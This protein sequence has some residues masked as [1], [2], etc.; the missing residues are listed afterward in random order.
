MTYIKV[1]D[2][3]GIVPRTGPTRLEANQA[4]IAYNVKLQSRELRSWSNPTLAY[5]PATAGVKTIYRIDSPSGEK[6]WLEW[7]NDV[8]MVPGPVADV[9]EYRYYYTGD[10]APKKTN[11]ALAT[12]SGTGVKPF[13]NSW[14]YMGVPAPTAGPTLVKTG[15]SG[16][17]H[18]DRAYVYTY[19]STFGSVKEESGPSPAT[20][21]STVEPNATVTVSGFAAAPTTGYNITHRRIYRTIVGATSVV[22]S[23]V[24][25]IPIATTSY[26]DTKLT[27][28]LG[29]ALPSLYWEPPPSDLQGLVAMPNGILAA[30]KG[31]QIWFSEPYYPHSWPS[32]YMLTVDYPIVGLGVFETTLVVLT[33]RFP[34]LISGVSPTSMTQQKLP[35]PQPCVSKK[36]IATD[37]YGVLYAS[38]SGLV[39]IGSG[40]QDVITTPLYTHD[41]WTV[42]APESMIAL[43]YNNLYIAFYTVNGITSAIVLARGDIPPLV[44]LDYSA[45]AVFVDRSTADIFAVSTL[46]NKIYQLDSSAVNNTIY[47]W[48]SKKF[49]LPEPTNFAAGKVQADYQYMTDVEAYNAFVAALKAANL[50]LYTASGGQVGGTIDGQ[51]FNLYTINGSALYDIP[52]IG[53]TRFVNFILYAD[54]VQVFAKN[55]VNQEPFRLPALQKGYIYEIL[56]SGNVPVRSAVIAS[57]IGELR[58]LNG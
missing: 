46:D 14:L 29:S 42:L 5:T 44:D 18:E 55:C 39:S 40:T 36:S 28:E 37:Q 19:V 27:A 38:P 48:K 45:K 26:A 35:I 23:F 47:E 54:G 10:G 21:I 2:F 52:E 57:S 13:P 41:E 43:I 31:N 17:V 16:T 12:T 32:I 50:A 11:Y 3:S 1:E 22:Y 53:A 25:E 33:T 7:A 9:D 49:V 4:Q 24:A 20:N 34:Y 51:E 58:Q 6:Y 15:G 56:L 8:D 30:F